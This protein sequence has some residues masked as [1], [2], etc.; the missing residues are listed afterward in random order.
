MRSTFTVRRIVR[1]AAIIVGLV[2]GIVLAPL[3]LAAMFTLRNEDLPEGMIALAAPLLLVPLAITAAVRPRLGGQ[4]LT[5][6]AA[7]SATA[8]LWSL[9]AVPGSAMEEVA[10]MLG[11]YAAICGLGVA[12]WWSGSRT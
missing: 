9:M 7:L 6:A 2:A 3:I 11:L 10:A 12:F 8:Y 1:A 5:T 4:L